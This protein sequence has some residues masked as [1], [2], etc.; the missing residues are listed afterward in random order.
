MA[1]KRLPTLLIGLAILGGALVLAAWPETTDRP[2]SRPTTGARTVEVGTVESASSSREL[3]LPGVTRAVQRATLSFAIPAR[4]AT[5]SVEVGDPVVR[6]QVLATLDDREYRLAAN[7]AAA[8]LAELE[9]RLDQ[10]RRDLDRTE[11]LAAA[12][13]AT[14]E[15]V[16]QVRTAAAALTAAR[17]AAAARQAETGRLRDESVLR[18][19]FDATV[20]A[21]HL[22]PGEWASPG[23]PVVELSGRNGLEVEVEAPESVR[24]RIVRGA[25]VA[26]SLPFLGTTARGRVASVADAATATGGLFPVRVTLEPSPGLVAGVAAEVV[27]DL[28]ATTSLTV[29]LRAVID[30]G[31][32]RPTVFRIADGRAHRVEIVPG[33]LIGDR[34]T[35]GGDVTAGDVVAVSGHTSLADNDPV[36][37]F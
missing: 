21:V 20:T 31:S 24:S 6:G 18:A 35:V 32:G 28:E 1:V 15:E 13:A 11:R 19:P 9:A 5:R 4:L 25:H 2:A 3:R 29:P 34:L 22:E 23:H 7:A 17:D 37:V 33:R 16:E 10:A 14:T 8:A 12:R 36:E 30:P 27:F 26:V